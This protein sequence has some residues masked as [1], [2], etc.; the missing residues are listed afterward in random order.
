MC[1]CLFIT[2]IINV[3]DKGK[4]DDE[5]PVKN[6]LAIDPLNLLKPPLD[7]G[8]GFSISGGN[9]ESVT[10][11]NRVILFVSKRSMLISVALNFVATDFVS[12]LCL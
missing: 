11:P 2:F 7:I 6:F 9:G 1:C 10:N 8:I 12:V 5:I 3:L 4:A